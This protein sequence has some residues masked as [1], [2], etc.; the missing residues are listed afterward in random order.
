MSI[1]SLYSAVIFLNI[2]NEINSVV[3]IKLTAVEILI[4]INIEA[5]LNEILRNS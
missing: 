5:R 4:I 2:N 3:E 1:V